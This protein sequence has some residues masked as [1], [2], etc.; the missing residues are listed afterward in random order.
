MKKLNRQILPDL[1]N[2]ERNSTV[3]EHET[4]LQFGGGNFLRGFIDFF[5][6]EL[7]EKNLYAGNIVIVQSIGAGLTESVTKQ[8][9][10]YTVLLRG[11]ENGKQIERTRVIT[12]VSR[13]INPTINHDE[14]IK[15]ADNPNLRFVVSNTTEAGIVYK[16]TDKLTDVPQSS[17]PG[18]VASFLYKRYKVFNGD[19]TKGLVFIPCELIDDNGDKLKEIVLKL[20]QNWNLE[21]D[22]IN[23]INNHNYFTNT[24]VDRI[25]PGYPEDATNIWEKLGYEDEIL[26]TAE[27]FEFFAIQPPTGAEHLADELPMQKLS[28]NILWTK[29]IKP[30]KLRKVRIL[31][32]AHTMSALIAY[33]AGKRTVREM[34]T[35][36]VIGKFIEKGIYDE[37]VPV[38]DMPKDELTSFAKSVVERFENPYI[39]HQ[40]ISISLNSVAKFKTRVL[41]TILDYYQKQGQIPTILTLSFA[42][43]IAF[44]KGDEHTVT[45]DQEIVQ[46]F[47]TIWK[48]NDYNDIAKKVCER[49][50]YWGQDLCN[51]TNFKDKV[52]EYLEKIE[53][54]LSALLKEVIDRR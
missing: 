22:F 2:V 25:V 41:P 53:T 40:L 3:A 24:L 13:A 14:Y 9:G 21:Q 29:D 10:L 12:S 31:N 51:L 44:Y 5:V 36:P 38:I 8:E 33:L 54:D 37:I 11:I 6:D 18:K 20:A 26:V 52:A 19:A 35:D 46:F 45:D 34:V 43:L 1:F 50:D 4:I 27:I 49:V 7:N 23:W 28:K 39:N 48:N 30:Y 47:Q 16:N 32:G 15:I 42:A 17:F